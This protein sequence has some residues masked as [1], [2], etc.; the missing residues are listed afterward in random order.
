MITSPAFSTYYEARGWLIDELMNIKAPITEIKI[1]RKRYV[2]EWY[3]EY[4][5]PNKAFREMVAKEIK[6]RN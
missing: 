1:Y 4:N 5:Q 6:E 2:Q 3:V